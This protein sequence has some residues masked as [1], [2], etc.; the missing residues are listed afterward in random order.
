MHVITVRNVN[1]ALSK[2]LKYLNDN[3]VKEESRNGPV[4]VA[5][6][7]VTTV[8][9]RP[10]ERVLFHPIRDA[11][12]FFHFMESLWMLAGRNDVD[13]V[14]DYVA[15]MEDFSDNGLTLNGAYGHRWRKH[16]GYDQLDAIINELKN[17]PQSR[18]MVLS[19]WDSRKD[20]W[21]AAVAR[22]NVKDVPCNTHAYFNVRK[23]DFGTY[24]DMTVCC[25]S[26]D[27]VWGAYGANAV[28]FS[29][30]QEYVALS[31]GARVGTLY[32]VSNNYHIYINRPDVSNLLVY[33]IA[34]TGNDYDA[35]SSM[36]SLAPTPLFVTDKQCFDRDLKI[37]IENPEWMYFAEPFFTDVALPIREAHRRYKEKDFDAALSIAGNI[38][39]KA[40]RIACEQWL[41]RRLLRQ[42]TQEGPC[43]SAKTEARCSKCSNE[44]DCDNCRGK[45]PNA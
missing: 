9:L 27:V 14:K 12:P 43:A 3:G 41:K 4:V 19:M 39:D 37:F 10:Y 33:Y 38:G 15:R 11:N 26:N 28:H 7:P 44:V 18:R 35:Y 29:Y 13:F 16:F 23:G 36:A 2:G 34:D 30:L 31:I 45:A 40:W 42:S 22:R 1:E 24:L 20:L 32:Q 5:P 17:N 25:R 21:D 8:Y 6:M